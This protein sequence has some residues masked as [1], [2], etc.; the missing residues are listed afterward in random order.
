[1]KKSGEKLQWFPDEDG[2]SKSKKIIN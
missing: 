1:L 2:G